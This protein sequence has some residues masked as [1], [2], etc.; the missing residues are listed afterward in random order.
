MCGTGRRIP[1]HFYVEVVGSH[2]PAVWSVP[3]REEAV[4]GRITSAATVHVTASVA[5]VIEEHCRMDSLVKFGLGSVV[6]DDHVL[7][8]GVSKLIEFLSLIT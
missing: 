2:N 8:I 5:V 3:P 1:R 4:S 7:V 6:R